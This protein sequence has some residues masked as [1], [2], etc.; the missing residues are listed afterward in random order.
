MTTD[1]RTDGHTDIIGAL[2]TPTHKIRE[3]I[4]IY[5]FPVRFAHRGLNNI[6]F[7]TNVGQFLLLERPQIFRKF[8][9]KALLS[10]L[11]F[12]IANVKIRS[13]QLLKYVARF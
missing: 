4:E 5:T 12:Y 2:Y 13:L 1:R 10:K 8:Q 3:L 6:S 9:Q 11:N 7:N